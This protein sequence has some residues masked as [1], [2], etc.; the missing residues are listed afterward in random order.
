MYRRHTQGTQGFEVR[1][2]RVALVG[3]K[4]IAGVAPFQFN[5]F[6]V[7]LDLRQDGC[8]GDGGTRSSP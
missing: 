2:G 7:A 3:G 6:P 5:Q 8:R 1:H 4:T